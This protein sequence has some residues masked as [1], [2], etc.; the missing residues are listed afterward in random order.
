[1][2]FPTALRPEEEHSFHLFQQQK[3]QLW[4]VSLCSRKLLWFDSWDFDFFSHHF[5][6]KPQ[7][8]RGVSMNDLD[9][10]KARASDPAVCLFPTFSMQNNRQVFNARKSDQSINRSTNQPTNQ[11][12]NRQSINCQTISQVSSTEDMKRWQI[13]HASFVCCIKI[14]EASR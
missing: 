13:H 14:V 2:L 11:S 5:Q 3:G 9:T 1:M 12:I 8:S 4:M 10:M 6:D 7:S